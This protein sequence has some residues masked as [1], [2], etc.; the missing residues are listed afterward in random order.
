MRILCFLRCGV[1]QTRIRR[2]ILRLEI[3]DRFKIGCIGYDLGKFLQLLELIRF[4]FSFFLFSNGSAH[5]V[6]FLFQN[7]RPNE[8][9]TMIKSR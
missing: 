8:R 6:S 2:R 9:S 7:V 4:R 3:L 1:N 5:N